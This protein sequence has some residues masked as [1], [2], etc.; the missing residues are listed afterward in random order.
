MAQLEVR[1]RLEALYKS[2]ITAPKTLHLK[3]GMCLSCVYKIINKIN[4]GDSMEIQSGRGRTPLCDGNDKRRLVQIALSH[5]TSSAREI[6]VR[7]LERGGPPLS[8]RSVQRY[9]ESSGCRK[10]KPKPAI[11]P[12]AKAK[13]GPFC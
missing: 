7:A 1:K 6:E 12:R 3:T 5:P 8:E 13:T 2:G 10:I 11:N 9:L 4:S